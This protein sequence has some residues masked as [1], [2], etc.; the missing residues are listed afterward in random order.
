MMAAKDHMLEQL[1]GQLAT[2]SRDLGRVQVSSPLSHLAPSLGQ[3]SPTAALL[4]WDI[5]R[6]HSN[7]PHSFHKATSTQSSWPVIDIC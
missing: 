7:K 3:T 2:S 5:N 4:P 6:E 1:R